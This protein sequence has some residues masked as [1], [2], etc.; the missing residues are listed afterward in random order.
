MRKKTSSFT[1]PVIRPDKIGR[2]T[3]VL[4]ELRWRIID[5]LVRDYTT[6]HPEEMR[7]WVETMRDIRRSKRDERLGMNKSGSMRQ[8][9]ALPMGLAV[10]IKKYDP[11]VFSDKKIMHQFMKLF[12]GF[13]IPSRI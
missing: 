3:L 13:R 10:L 12:P 7:E 1:L 9:L 8:A 4:G 6:L 11:E 2:G 5:G